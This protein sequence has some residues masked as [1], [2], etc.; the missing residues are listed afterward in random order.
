MNYLRNLTYLIFLMTFSL[1]AQAQ[2]ENDSP[3]YRYFAVSL[4]NLTS[5]EFDQFT[6]QRQH[7]DTYEFSEFCN[8]TSQVLVRCD[9]S[10]AKRI[11]EMKAEVRQI[12]QKQFSSTRIETIS[13]ISYSDQLNFCK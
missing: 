4:Q 11:D 2:T 3:Y 7:S 10:V 13:R 9:A 1:S 6:S 5:A 8:L 12:L